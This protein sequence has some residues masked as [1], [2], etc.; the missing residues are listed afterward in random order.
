[1][2][3]LVGLSGDVTCENLKDAFLTS[4]FFSPHLQEL[5]TGRLALQVEEVI[6]LQLPKG[7]R[8][9]VTPVSRRD[10]GLTEH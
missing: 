5:L 8:R 2:S 6:V 7:W 4:Q 3:I 9:G 1:V 10:T